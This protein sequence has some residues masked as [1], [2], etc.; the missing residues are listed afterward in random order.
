[1]IIID[2]S[3]NQSDWMTTLKDIMRNRSNPMIQMVMKDGMIYVTSYTFYDG[4]VGL[5][6]YDRK[7]A[8]HSRKPIEVRASEYNLYSVVSS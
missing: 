3:W 6:E 1:M 4:T 7:R 2:F 8:D 5:R